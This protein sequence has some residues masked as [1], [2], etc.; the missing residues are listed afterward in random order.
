MSAVTKPEMMAL[1]KEL[2]EHL[3]YCGWGDSWEREVAGD[4]PQRAEALVSKYE[5][6]EN[7]SIARAKEGGA[8]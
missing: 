3:D 8:L 1:I 5:C 2:I 6:A 7:E 4:L